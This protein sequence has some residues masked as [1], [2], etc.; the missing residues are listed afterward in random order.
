MEIRLAAKKDSRDIAEM[1][2]ELFRHVYK[3]SGGFKEATKLRIKEVETEELFH[4]RRSHEWKDC[5]DG[6]S[7]VA[8]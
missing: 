3:T 6:S 5:W 7:S 4:L 8:W 1:Y 2:L